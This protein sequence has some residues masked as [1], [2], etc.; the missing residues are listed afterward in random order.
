MMKQGNLTSFYRIHSEPVTGEIKIDA[1]SVSYWHNARYD[2]HKLL[3]FE[4]EGYTDFEGTIF[5]E[6]GYKL[7]L[8]DIDPNQ[9]AYYSF[10][11][12]IDAWDSHNRATHYTETGHREA[13][14]DYEREW[15]GTYEDKEE[16][17]RLTY[18]KEEFTDA[19]KVKIT[20]ERWIT[21]PSDKGQMLSYH[22]VVTDP[23]GNQTITDWEGTYDDKDRLIEYHKTVLDTA[24]GTTIEVDWYGSYNNL[25]Q[26]KSET[27]IETDAETGK[28]QRRYLYNIRYNI[29]GKQ[30][31]FTE[32]L[33]DDTGT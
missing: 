6:K 21:Y 19:N 23:M 12:T 30:A 18:Y 31:S 29:L 33:V 20:T 3:Y 15:W 8:T 26:L 7:T 32:K 24:I 27:Y 2:G 9:A 13:T 14:G 22:E 11:R 25:G 10:S 28:T 4:E 5:D 17:A 1:G 16:G